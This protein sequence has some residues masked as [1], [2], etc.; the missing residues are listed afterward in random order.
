LQENG[1]TELESE[2]DFAE[3]LEIRHAGG[4]GVPLMPLHV[5]VTVRSVGRKTVVF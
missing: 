1:W 4:I 5:D 2:F 3:C